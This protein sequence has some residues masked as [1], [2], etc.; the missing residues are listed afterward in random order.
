MSAE[1]RNAKHGARRNGRGRIMVVASVVVVCLVIVTGVAWGLINRNLTP[2]RRVDAGRVMGVAVFSPQNGSFVPWRNRNVMAFIYGDGSY[3]LVAG[4]MLDGARPVWDGNGL[5]IPG[6]GKDTL[7]DWQDG[8]L[9]TRT[10]DNPKNGFGQRAG[11]SYRGGYFGAYSNGGPE[12]LLSVTDADGD[13]ERRTV[14]FAR[15]GSGYPQPAAY[16][17]CGD[18]VYALVSE[19]D[20]LETL[21]RVAADGRIIGE[22]RSPLAADDAASS[23]GEPHAVVGELVM[24][25]MGPLAGGMPMATSASCDADAFYVLAI[26]VDDATG[27]ANADGRDTGG[28]GEKSATESE[29][30]TEAPLGSWTHV[31]TGERATRHAIP[32]GGNTSTVAVP[33][34]TTASGVSPATLAYADP[35][36][37]GLVYA[38]LERWDIASRTRTVI[39]LAD[40]S[41]KQLQLSSYE[42]L[43]GD[44][45]G[46]N[47]LCDGF[48][49]WFTGE[50][51]LMH[52]RVATGATTVVGGSVINASE[53]NRHRLAAWAGDGTAT[54]LSTSPS[55]SSDNS[56]LTAYDL[57]SDSVVTQLL[58]SGLEEK[59]RGMGRN[60]ILQS[61]TA[62][63]ATT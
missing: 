32:G 22:D 63:P 43:L 40:E 58:L 46:G 21:Y 17:A 44:F 31:W 27:S 37:A 34:T 36:G 35:D 54:A 5:Y 24:E 8:K 55:Q 39:P 57:D 1:G 25:S 38:S 47:V 52:T 4:D 23:S 9:R 30:V 41:G 3:D 11:F 13:V 53:M 15:N 48:L 62:K 19:E 59:V 45:I 51:K 2:L 56:T 29:T 12:A 7:V 33:G 18:D 10:L 16:A 6:G 20:G 28:Q 14:T 49:R 50:G 42:M 26:Q 60:M 61:Y